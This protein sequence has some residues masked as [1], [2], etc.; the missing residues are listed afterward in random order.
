MVGML[1]DFE[2]QVVLVFKMLEYHFSLTFGFE[3]YFKINFGP[4]LGMA[5]L[6]ILPN[7]DERQQKKLQ[8]I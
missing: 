7:H 8:Y 2:H 5:R 6:E 4:C 1:K 3:I